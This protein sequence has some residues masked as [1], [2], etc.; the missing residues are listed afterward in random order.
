VNEIELNYRR[1]IHNG[2]YLELQVI[3]EWRDDDNNNHRIGGPAYIHYNLN[4]KVS[5]EEYYRHG[6]LHRRDGPAYILYNQNGGINFVKY[7]V[8]GFFLGNDTD[9]FWRLWDI[10]SDMERKDNN[11]LKILVDQ[12]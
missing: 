3:Q 5:C 1:S 2:R 9:G 12:K 8:N 4:G 6:S 10:L 7:Y 11:I